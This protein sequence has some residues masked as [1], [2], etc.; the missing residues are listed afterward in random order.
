[1]KLGVFAAGG[2][3]DV[4]MSPGDGLFCRPHGLRG[5]LACPVPVS[6]LSER[7]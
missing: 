5:S 3:I 2:W 4:A 6:H 1:M 7:G